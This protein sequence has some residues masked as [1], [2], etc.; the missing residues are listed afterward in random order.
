MVIPIAAV[1]SWNYQLVPSK[2]TLGVPSGMAETTSPGISE[3]FSKTFDEKL[4]TSFGNASRNFIVIYTR[5]KSLLFISGN[6]Q[7]FLC[8]FFLNCSR[9][10]QF[11]F[12][13]LLTKFR[14]F[15]RNQKFSRNPSEASPALFWNFFNKFPE[16]TLGWF[17]EEIARR[18]FKGALEKISDRDPGG[19][20]EGILAEF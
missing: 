18:F 10:S 1:L 6:P 3:H 5:R 7:K 20:T 4:S 19:I 12:Q 13:F 2:I 16:A 14:I 8:N 17:S 9:S 15:F 11:F